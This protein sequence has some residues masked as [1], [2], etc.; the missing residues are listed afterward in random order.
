[1]S[2]GSHSPSFT[3]TFFFLHR[4]P[5]RPISVFERVLFRSEQAADTFSLFFFFICPAGRIPVPQRNSPP[6]GSFSSDETL[7]ECKGFYDSR[8][9]FPTG[10]F[11]SKDCYSV[12]TGLPSLKMVL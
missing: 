4:S 1:V 5:T 12:C 7:Y 10:S 8:L 2:S 9:S 11:V 6:S 3:E